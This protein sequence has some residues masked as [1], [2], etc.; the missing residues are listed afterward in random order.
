[1]VRLVLSMALMCLLG[2]AGCGTASVAPVAAQ[3]P[4]QDAAFG[5][6]PGL[7][8]V[9]QG[10]VARLDPEL[11]KK[12]QDADVRQMGAPLR[13]KFL[14]TL[15]F[16]ADL[17]RFAYEAG[18]STTPAE[19]W[20]RQRGDCLSLTMLTYAVAKAMDMEAIMQEVRVPVLFDRRGPL[21][22]VNQHVNVLFP[23][24]H[25]KP[26]LEDNVARDVVIDF[27]PGYASAAKGQPLSESAILARY[28]NNIATE[29]LAQG[30]NALAYA[31]YKAA[32]LADPG[33]AA[34][35]GNLAIL[36]RNGGLL[37]DSEQLLRH[38]VALGDPGD[39]PLR[40]LY[41]L[42]S[43]QGRDAE[44]RRYARE[45]Q[46]HRER[47]PYYWIGLGLQHLQAGENRQAIRAL[48]HARDMATGFEEVHRHLALAYWRAGEAAR[49]ND[50]LSQLAA[51]TGD[52][53]GVSR[54]RKKFKGSPAQLQP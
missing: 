49:A 25:R 31:H 40:A 13:L 54:L 33:Y 44:A 6:E 12:I 18:H 34:S 26:P 8:T 17:R 45:L 2:L 27:E 38:A 35:Y 48:E 3:L 28:Y 22:V 10:D 46:A 7:V 9:A 19:T 15:V 14:M 23:R 29:H 32:I 11:L 41:Q 51:L 5:Y 42:L 36:Y 20:K 4:W 43:E 52:E 16:G 39:V 50:E 37:R 1:M 47:D 30:R 53:A 21:D 24:A